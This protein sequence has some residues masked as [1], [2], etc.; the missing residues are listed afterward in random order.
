MGK[1]VAGLSDSVLFYWVIQYIISL[2]WVIYT[3][4]V[5][6][7]ICNNVVFM[8]C[9]ITGAWGLHYNDCVCKC[10]SVD[11][12]IFWICIVSNI[13]LYNYVCYYT[14]I[15]FRIFNSCP[16]VYAMNE[17]TH[18]HIHVHIYTLTF[19]MCTH[20]PQYAGSDGLHIS[21]WTGILR[22]A[23]IAQ[24]WYISL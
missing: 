11:L 1:L 20:N 23:K 4:T 12:S 16:S 6:F 5:I 2:I 3:H 14:C 10:V 19:L 18:T 9:V 7:S 21:S 13:T 24:I 8:L 17:H 22:V 15:H